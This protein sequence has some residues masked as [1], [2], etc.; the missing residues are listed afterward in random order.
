[1]YEFTQKSKQ[2]MHA[3][4]IVPILFV[5]SFAVRVSRTHEIEPLTIEVRGH[6]WNLYKTEDFGGCGGNM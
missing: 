5:N 2:R 3:Q 6:W 1:M 4:N